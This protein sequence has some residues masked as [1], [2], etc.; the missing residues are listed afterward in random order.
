MKSPMHSG[1]FIT[2]GRYLRAFAKADARDRDARKL[3]DL[4]ELLPNRGMG[5]LFLTSGGAG[6]ATPSVSTELIADRKWVEDVGF[7][8]GMLMKTR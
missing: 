4:L 5:P 6:G 3:L 1:G 2:I 7:A 8:I